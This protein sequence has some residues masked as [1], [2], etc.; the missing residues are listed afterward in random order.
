MPPGSTARLISAMV[1]GILSLWVAASVTIGHGIPL[2]FASLSVLVLMAARLLQGQKALPVLTAAA[3]LALALAGAS[4]LGRTSPG[5][6]PYL[7]AAVIAAGASFLPV[8]ES[9]GG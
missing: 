2:R 8:A 7:L 9:R 3:G 5:L 1:G 4:A 6:A